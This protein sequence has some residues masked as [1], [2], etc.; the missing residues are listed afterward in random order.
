M[1]SS[2]KDIRIETGNDIVFSASEA[3][4]LTRGVVELRSQ[5]RAH[6]VGFGTPEL[7]KYLIPSWPGDLIL[8]CGRPQNYKT[9]YM[10]TL[11]HRT[12]ADIVKQNKM[13]ECVILITWEVSVE[14]AMAYWLA[15]DSG[16]SATDMMRGEI[17]K[18]WE[19]FDAAIVK[20]SSAPVYIIGHSIGRDADKKRRRPHLPPSVVN[21]ALDYIMNDLE[22]E[23]RM[24]SMDY[25]QRIHMEKGRGNDRNEHYLQCV[26]WAKD[27]AIWAGSAVYLGTQARR[28]VD[29]QTIKLPSLRDSQWSSNA[30]QSADK[31]LSLWMPKQSHDIG[32]TLNLG[33]NLDGITVSEKLLLMAVSKQKFGPAGRIFPLYVDPEHLKLGDA[34]IDALKRGGN[35]SHYQN[36]HEQERRQ[37]SGR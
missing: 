16:I 37:T 9:G 32:D 10:Q 31:F 20:V 25:L 1:A 23:P 14:Q 18:E 13:N 8:V 12:A 19:K 24:I 36:G 3:A 6:R 27:T 7:D 30:E 4:A 2:M 29:D 33:G 28:E 35:Y 5:Q 11:M 22:L 26:D 17:D 15:V 21:L 34:D